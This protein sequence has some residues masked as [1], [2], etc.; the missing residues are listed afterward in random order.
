MRA[1]L[2]LVFFFLVQSEWQLVEQIDDSLLFRCFVGLG[3]GD[4]MWHHAVFSKNRDRLQ[5]S[6]VA[7]RFFAEVNHRA[8]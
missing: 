1:L 5:T 4:S 6:K 3:M 8:K 7:K 2:L